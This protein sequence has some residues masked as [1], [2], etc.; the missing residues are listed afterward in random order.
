MLSVQFS[1][2]VVSDSLWPHVLQHARLPCPSPTPGACSNSCP[3][4]QWCHPT[5]SSS[6]V[7]LSSCLQSY[8][9][10]KPLLNPEEGKTALGQT[11]K[12]LSKILNPVA[13][14]TGMMHFCYLHI[15]PF[16]CR[17][18]L[19]L[20]SWKIARGTQSSY[21][22][23]PKCKIVPYSLQGPLW[24]LIASFKKHIYVGKISRSLALRWRK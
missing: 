1:R 22:R 14:S 2:S 19:P 3:S 5:I 8:T 16:G 4:S 7:P 24:V 9:C 21:W 15:T 6:I 10:S 17:P 12:I 18:W 13:S 11:Q 20:S 23:V